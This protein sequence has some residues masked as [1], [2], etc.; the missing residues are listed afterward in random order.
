MVTDQQVRKLMKLIQSEKSLAI[1]AAKA[2]MDEKTAGK[3]RRLGRLPSQCQQAH[4][5]MTQQDRFAE[6]WPE[7]RGQ[8]QLNPGLE[9][10]TV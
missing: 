6:V 2:G 3:Y 4:T 1:A 10:K 5:W 7:I 9:A 8:L